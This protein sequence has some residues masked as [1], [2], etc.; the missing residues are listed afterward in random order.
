[1]KPKWKPTTKDARLFILVAIIFGSFGWFSSG[2]VEYAHINH[3]HT[4]QDQLAQVGSTNREKLVNALKEAVARR[5]KESKE[6][7][8]ETGSY[9]ANIVDSVIF[10]GHF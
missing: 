5:E 3:P 6:K 2:V 4:H 10:H 8:Q 1:M 9:N 7:S